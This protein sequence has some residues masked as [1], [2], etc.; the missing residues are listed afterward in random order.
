MKGSNP[1]VDAPFVG[2]PSGMGSPVKYDSV[3]HSMSGKRPATSA[4]A[5]CQMPS[6]S[7][8]PFDSV[9]TV[10]AIG[11]CLASA[12]AA[13]VTAEAPATAVA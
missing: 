8:I 6:P 4:M 11:K 5:M 10:A 12:P 7:S 3:I 9:N 2:V 1:C 13:N